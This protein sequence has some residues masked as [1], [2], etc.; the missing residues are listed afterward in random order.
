MPFRGN[1][2]FQIRCTHFFMD[3]YFQ[4]VMAETSFSSDTFHVAFLIN[5]KTCIIF[6]TL[7][8]RLWLEG[9]VGED[10]SCNCSP[11]HLNLE[12]ICPIDTH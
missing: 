12:F 6:R 2:W 7:P 11:G 9:L 10:E 4:T 8:R 3:L 1:T 5:I